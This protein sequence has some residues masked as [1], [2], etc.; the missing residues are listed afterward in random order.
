MLVI[1][2]ERFIC[3]F[4]LLRKHQLPFKRSIRFHAP[5]QAE[6]QKKLQFF[7]ETAR[8]RQVST[9]GGYYSEVDMKKPRSEEGLALSQS[10]SCTIA[11]SSTLLGMI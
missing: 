6:F 2:C 3:S 5:L 9:H 11:Y 1:M 7:K 10:L 4:G 8:F